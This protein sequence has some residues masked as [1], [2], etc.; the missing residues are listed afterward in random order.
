MICKY[1]AC[2]EDC[3]YWNNYNIHKCYI[4]LFCDFPNTFFLNNKCCT[5]KYVFMY[6]ITSIIPF[7]C[8]RS[9]CGKIYEIPRTF[10]LCIYCLLCDCTEMQWPVDIGIITLML[11]LLQCFNHRIFYHLTLQITETCDENEHST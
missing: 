6:V 4:L 2:N 9:L 3:F 5:W 8:V 1:S 10:S 11:Q 7:L